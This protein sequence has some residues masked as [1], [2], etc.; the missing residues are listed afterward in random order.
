MPVQLAAVEAAP[1]PAVLPADLAAHLD[2]VEREILQRALV[3]YRYNRTA[4]GARLGLTLRQMRYR[5]ARLGIDVPEI[6]GPTAAGGE[7]EP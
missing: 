3:Q 2:E 7:R 6:G 1:A 5:M 4:A